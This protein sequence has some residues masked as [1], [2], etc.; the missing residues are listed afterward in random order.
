M[1]AR[2]SMQR[3]GRTLRLLL[4]LLRGIL[5]LWRTQPPLD[6]M[7]LAHAVQRW[8]HQL[9][10][11]VGVEIVVHGEVPPQGLLVLNHIS[12]LDVF[13]LNAI[14]PSH[15]VAKSEIAAWPLIGY[16]CRHTQTLF[17][18]RGKHHAARSANTAIKHWLHRGERVAIFP[19][20]TTSYG[21][22]VL[23]FHP[24]LL[25][26]AIDLAA[27]VHP[28]TLRYTDI[29]EAHTIAPSFVGAQT[30]AQS[31][32]TLLGERHITAHIHFSAALMA[33]G[34]HRRS[35]GNALREVIRAPLH[36]PMKA[37]ET[38]SHPQDATHSTRHPTH[39][40]YQS[41]KPLA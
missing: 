18:E 38:P 39:S 31:L 10:Q 40:P 7:P 41:H 23:P 20:G 25:Q 30:L 2:S 17:I 3:A 26:S 6:G 16:L 29:N 14:A 24:A 36:T 11:I 1:S 5:I 21:D 37:L 32:W 22:D 33:G 35:L 8:S 15:F 28:A 13:V 34:A 12:W 4:H 19:E 9:V 27:Y